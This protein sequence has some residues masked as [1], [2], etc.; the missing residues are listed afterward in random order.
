MLT[1]PL[2]YPSNYIAHSYC[3]DNTCLLRTRKIVRRSNHWN[4]PCSQGGK[5]CCLWMLTF[6]VIYW[7]E[8]QLSYDPYDPARSFIAK[9]LRKSPYFINSAREMQTK[10]NLLLYKSRLFGQSE[11]LKWTFRIWLPEKNNKKRKEKGGG[12]MIKCLLTD[13]GR[14]GRENI[15][16]SVMAHGPPCARSVRHD[17]GLNIFP[18]AALPLSL[19]YIFS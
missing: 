10:T 1:F 6:C 7:G 9:L 18:S 11:R 16:S 3:K 17:L 12:H 14:A 8:M 2:S 4:R 5:Q 13:L 15:W 19:Y